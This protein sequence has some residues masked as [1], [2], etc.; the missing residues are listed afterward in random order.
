TNPKKIN[1]MNIS[2]TLSAFATSAMLL[3]SVTS[4][5][6]DDD[7]NIDEPIPS[8]DLDA[9]KPQNEA[10]VSKA[11]IAAK[12]NPF[13]DAYYYDVMQYLWSKEYKD[14]TKKVSKF[15]NNAAAAIGAN[16]Q[17]NTAVSPLSVFM[18]LS[19]A[20]ESAN[21]DT[22]QEIL[23]AMGI[24][25]EELAAN[26][27]YL[28]YTCNQVLDY[29]ESNSNGKNRIKSINSLW[30]QNGVQVKDAGVNSLTSNYFADLFNMDFEGSDVN[31]IIKSYI[32]NETNGL[33]SPDLELNADTYLV[34]MNVV[35]LR[36][37]W[38]KYGNDLPL[39]DK[40]Y[41]FVNYDR[42]TLSTKL[43]Q[44][45]Y[46]SGKAV[47][48]EKFRKFYNTTN[49]G[50]SMTFFVPKD[51]YTLDDIYT[52]DVL[53]DPTPYVTIDVTSDPEVNY[54]FHTRCF[55]PEFEASFDDD[56]KDVIHKMGVNKFF[57]RG[58]CDFSN[59]TDEGV[60]CSQIRHITKLEVSRKGIEGA[61]VTV[62]YMDTNAD[63]G[64]GHEEK[65]WEDVY[66]D[67]PVDRNFAYVL[68]KDG[69][70]IFTGV[71]KNIK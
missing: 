39:T 35:Y 47:E 55:F 28:C 65:R 61:A 37:I 34:L 56:I 22:R 5:D 33:L 12:V 2:K 64:P 54:R 18:A 45:Y 17:G 46:H 14:F 57:T 32:S 52:S 40:T 70:P 48:T 67:F 42:S 16:S 36:D 69:V 11:M 3:F 60:F 66:Y 7:N 20:A 51:G 19:M 43:L 9:Y 38:N 10:A 29:G 63:P 59:L 30:V 62:E 58:G 21:G 1:N 23:D 50:L 71:V 41:D 8:T 15:S 31:E 68:S 44:G 24:T 27:K 49:S 6:K 4:C 26:I 53:N 13:K 25:Y